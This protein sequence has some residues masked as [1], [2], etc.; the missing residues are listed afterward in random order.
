MHLEGTPSEQLADVLATG[1]ADIG[2]LCYLDQDP[3]AVVATPTL[4]KAP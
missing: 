4:N 2:S 3:V 1:S